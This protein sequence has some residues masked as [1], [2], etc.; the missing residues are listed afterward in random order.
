MQHAVLEVRGLCKSFGSS[1]V[2]RDVDLDLHRGQ[3]VALLG[4]NGAGKTTLVNILSTLVA[5][6]Y[7]EASINGVDIR[8]DARRA[9]AHFSLTGQYAALDDFQTGEENLIMM[10]R[11]GGL[12]RKAAILR[13]AELLEGFGLADASARK[14][15]TYSGGMR[16]RLDLAAGIAAAP[17]VL[18]LDEPTT[19][20][21][22][23]SRHQL[24]EH[25]QTL[26][27]SGTAILLTTQYLEEADQLA[28]HIL[29]LN[30]GSIIAQGTAEELKAS[31]ATSH[32]VRFTFNSSEDLEAAVHLLPKDSRPDPL[33]LSVLVSTENAAETIRRSLRDVDGISI[34][35]ITVIKPSLDD[36]FLKL[37]ATPS[38]TGPSTAAGVTA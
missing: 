31:L 16:R 9:R 1:P 29:L 23:Q 38:A 11:L 32:Y 12:G 8:R 35:G 25:I 37:T 3:I 13:A 14:T 10:G 33:G 21:D 17:P 4:P 30:N 36:V 19:G 20:L 22:P 2:L 7:G 26:T 5:A 6:D 34:S 28:D 27:A 24:W 15:G 18:F